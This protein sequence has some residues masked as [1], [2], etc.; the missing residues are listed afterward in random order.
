MLDLLAQEELLIRKNVESIWSFKETSNELIEHAI[1]MLKGIIQDYLHSTA[2]A[3][4][5]DQTLDISSK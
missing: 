1:V 5:A 2:M 3:I 4:Q